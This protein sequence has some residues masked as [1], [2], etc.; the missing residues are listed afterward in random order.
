MHGLAPIRTDEQLQDEFDALM[1][2]ACHGERRALGAIAI[3][4]TP[5]L[6]EEARAELGSLESHAARVVAEALT[7]I[8]EG[9]G[10][11]DP[12]KE[13]AI[14][15]IK[16]YLR[17]IAR[18]HLEWLLALRSPSLEGAAPGRRARA[19]HAERRPRRRVGRREDNH[20]E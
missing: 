3:A 6:F 11:F 8:S 13:R 10:D 15:W 16:R 1:T 4:L 7:T 9:A 14:V 18:T 20:H 12:T 2:L 19:R 17:K 5:T